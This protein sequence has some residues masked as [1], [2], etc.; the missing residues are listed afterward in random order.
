MA[1]SCAKV[2]DH[3]AETAVIGSV[4][5]GPDP[6]PRAFIRLSKPDGEFMSEVECGPTGTFHM[7]VPPGDWRLIC[8]VPRN[9]LEQELSLTRGDQYRVDFLLVA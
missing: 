2:T 5:R 7:S 6:A 1:V 8:L 9:R 4:R 3:A